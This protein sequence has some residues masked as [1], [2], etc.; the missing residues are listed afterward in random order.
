MCAFVNSQIV[1]LQPAILVLRLLFI[2]LI[3]L[4]YQ[5]ERIMFSQEILDFWC[6][7]RFLDFV[8]IPYLLVVFPVG[9]DTFWCVDGFVI[10]N[11][12]L[13]L[14][15]LLGNIEYFDADLRTS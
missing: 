2:K 4:C 15:H 5:C 11:P 1:G 10:I 7:D 12:N 6:V 3:F 9:N 13:I 14:L 8:Q